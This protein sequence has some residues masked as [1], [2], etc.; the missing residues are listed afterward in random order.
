ATLAIVGLMAT[1]VIASTDEILQWFWW[2]DTPEGDSV[3]ISNDGTTADYV[4]PVP[5][6]MGPEV[7]QFLEDGGLLFQIED[8]PEEDDPEGGEETSGCTWTVEE[9]FGG[10]GALFVTPLE[11]SGD[12]PAGTST[13]Q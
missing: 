5:D 2:I 1:A 9:A 12:E 4:V 7:V 3:I 13:D 8:D 11:G 6:G 10:G